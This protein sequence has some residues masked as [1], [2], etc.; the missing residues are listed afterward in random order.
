MSEKQVCKIPFCEIEIHCNGDVYICCPSKMLQPIG[1]LYKEPFDKV[2][3][4]AKAKEI[5][6]EILLN[7]NYKYCNLRIC[8]PLDNIETDKLKLMYN[9]EIKLVENPDYPLYVKF[10]HDTHCNLRCVTCRDNYIT[11]SKEQNEKLDSKIEEVFLPVLK[12]CKIVSLN[13]AGEIFASKHCRNLVKA[14]VGAYPEIKFDLHTN[15]VL[16]DKKNC[17]ELGI[18]DKLVSIDI[19]MHAASKETYEKIM[20]GSNYER[21][22]DNIKWLS[23]L[24]QAGKLKRLD[25]YFVV[26]KMNYKEMPDF[27]RF[28]ESVNADVYFWEYRN[29]GN[30]WGLKNYDTVAVYEKWHPEYNKFARLLQ[31]KIFSHP[32]CHLNNYLKTI[33]PINCFKHA[34]L[35]LPKC[36]EKLAEKELHKDIFSVKNVYSSN[37]KRKVVKIL[38]LK[39]SFRVKHS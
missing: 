20:I 8:N 33:K 28:A 6:N 36:M 29:W 39:L 16:C 15:G 38:G 31:N 13:G 32:N 7:N 5:R 2:W 11:N 24:K 12:N 1:N 25:L 30:E 9:Q 3:Y 23:G 18:T 35:V 26:Q 34:K 4:S 37:I 21:V 14:I 17:D 27:V 22:L 19:S 10:C